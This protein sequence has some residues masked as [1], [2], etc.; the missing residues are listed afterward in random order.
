VRSHVDAP[1]A[2]WQEQA[3][4]FTDCCAKWILEGDNPGLEYLHRRGLSDDT[5]RTWGLGW[6]DQR[7][8]KY[9]DPGKWGLDGGKRI[10][11]ARG[12]TIPWTVEGAVYHVK[13]RLF[14]DWGEDMPKYIRVRGGTPTLYGLDHLAGRDTVVICEGEL[15]A[16]LLWQEAGDLVDV[17]AIGTKGAKIEPKGL[18][19]LKAPRWLVAL[20]NDADEKAREWIAYTARAKRI[21]PM[22][23]NDVTD[24]HAAGGDLRS[25]ILHHLEADALE[26]SEALL[27]GGLEAPGARDRYLEIQR[28][29]G[30]LRWDNGEWIA[31]N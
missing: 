14:E 24:F 5:I 6:Y 8:G 4:T 30:W 31:P 25:W 28:S 7:Y 29:R 20:D 9:R 21:R 18:A 19:H 23:G 16:V 15:D 12:L 10:Y 26:R 3:A 1:P 17:V 27:S 2:E 11:L 13:L 22:E